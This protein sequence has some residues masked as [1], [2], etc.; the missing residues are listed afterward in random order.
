[1]AQVSNGCI[2][3]CLESAGLNQFQDPDQKDPGKL[4]QPGDIPFRNQFGSRIMM[5]E[6][7]YRFDGGQNI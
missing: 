2:F 1:M 3:A 4:A 5:S 7:Y 6:R